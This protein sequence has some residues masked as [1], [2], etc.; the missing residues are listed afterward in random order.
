LSGCSGRQ[1][2]CRLRAGRR[3]GQTRA[4]PRPMAGCNRSPG[5][6]FCFAFCFRNGDPKWRDSPEKKRF[7]IHLFWTKFWNLWWNTIEEWLPGNY[8]FLVIWFLKFYF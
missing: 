8:K 4:S 7:R 3:R 6:V 1:A 2:R 5:P